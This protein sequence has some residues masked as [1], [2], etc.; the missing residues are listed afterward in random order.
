MT[1]YLERG[2]SFELKESLPSSMEATEI[3][4]ETVFV[5][6]LGNFRTFH[7]SLL[8]FIGIKVQDKFISEFRVAFVIFLFFSV[9]LKYFTISICYFS[10][11]KTF[12]K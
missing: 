2:F 5:R 1:F 10:S 9:F 4:S 12:L 6:A 7:I 11:L 8:S 3:M